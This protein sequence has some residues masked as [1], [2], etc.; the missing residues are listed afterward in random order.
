MTDILLLRP[1]GFSFLPGLCFHGVE[2]LHQRALVIELMHMGRSEIK[3]RLV[4]PGLIVG[5]DVTAKF[6]ARR[7]LIGIVPHQIDLFLFDRPIE[8]L[9]QRI[10]GWP[11]DPGKR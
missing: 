7:Y 5:F 1:V 3:Q 8:P 9:S 10:V 6:L 2:F 11:S 4:R